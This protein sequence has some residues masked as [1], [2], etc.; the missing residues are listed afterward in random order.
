MKLFYKQ[1]ACSL[2]SH[3]ILNEIGVD[4]DLDQVDTD[5]GTTAAG[6][7]YKAINPK[8]YVPALAISDDVV[9]TEGPSILQYLADQNPAA[10]LI[11]Q[12]G[13]VER[14]RTTEYLNY[15]G[16]ELHKS[17]SPL[18]VATTSEAGKVAAK[19]NVERRFDYVQGLLTD[20]DY[21]LGADFS[22]A[23]A[24]LA[25]VCNWSNFVGIDLAKWPAIQDFVSRVFARP[26]AQK[27]LKLEGLA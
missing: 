2:A 9:L 7:N 22:V 6:L 17:F 24:Y 19:E 12:T 16:S 15:V 1:G 13:T 11:G 4:Y 26:A 18:F 14:A 8:G 27:A 20:K 3:I 5:A 21:L 23:D 25:V 10:K